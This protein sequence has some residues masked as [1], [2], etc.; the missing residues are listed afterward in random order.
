MGIVLKSMNET[1][2]TLT[3][4]QAEFMMLDGM[5]T[6][7]G[8]N[9]C[10]GNIKDKASS[11]DK[12]SS[13]SKKSEKDTSKSKK[14]KC[15]SEKD[16][17]KKSETKTE[18]H[19]ASDREVQPKAKAA[20]KKGSR[21]PVIPPEETAAKQV[22]GE[23][24]K[25]YVILIASKGDWPWIRKC[26]HLGVGFRNKKKCCNRGQQGEEKLTTRHFYA[27]GWTGN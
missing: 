7:W 9:F 12:K 5:Q 8:L 4:K 25:F 17:S 10:E 26:Y 3:N 2:D 27:N 15:K 23:K 6:G 19:S 16:K 21:K 11:K 24:Q 22:D 14:D 13:K 18:D 1:Y 20:A